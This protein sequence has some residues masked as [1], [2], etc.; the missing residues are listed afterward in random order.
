MTQN[1]KQTT[2][3]DELPTVVFDLDGTLAETGLDLVETLNRV[4]AEIEVPPIGFLQ[5]RTMIGHG[6]RALITLGL[7]SLHIVADDALMDQLFQRFMVIYEDQLCVKTHLYPDVLT[8]LQSLHQAGYR[9]AVCTNKIEKHS[10]TLLQKL[11]IAH[12]FKAICGRDTFPYFKPDARHLVD[13]IKQAGGNPRK[14]I[15]VGD[16]ITD[17]DTARNAGLP[18]IGV[19]FGYT[20]TPMAEMKPDRL[21]EHYRDLVA[22][23]QSL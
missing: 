3:S 6:A 4:L 16:S 17:L 13:T 9:M 20:T 5:A 22:A 1:M 15:M 19:T 2:A 18:S 8:A 21:I 12:Y 14:A 7:E 23:I 11:E 10:I